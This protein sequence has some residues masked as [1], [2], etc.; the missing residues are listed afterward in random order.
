MV[1]ELCEGGNLAEILS[2]RLPDM[3]LDELEARDLM[4]QVFD[5]FRKIHALGYVHRDIKLENLF[6]SKRT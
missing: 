1:M 3:R 2:E 5:V 4:R 6:I